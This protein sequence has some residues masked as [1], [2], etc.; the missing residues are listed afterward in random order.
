M[1]VSG[2]VAFITAA[3]IPDGGSLQVFGD[4]LFATDSAAYAGQRIG[5]VV[6]SSQVPAHFLSHPQPL[7]CYGFGQERHGLTWVQAATVF[8]P[9]H[10]AQSGVQALSI[11]RPAPVLM[12]L[13]FTA[14]GPLPRPATCELW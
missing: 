12:R 7:L 8:V 14:A 3:D 4:A 2:F 13:V 9:S 6:A 10:V 5:L 1:Q 11:S